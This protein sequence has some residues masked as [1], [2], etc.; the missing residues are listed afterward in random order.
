MY[1]ESDMAKRIEMLKSI[2]KQAVCGLLALFFFGMIQVSSASDDSSKAGY[3]KTAMD[4]VKSSRLFQ[5]MKKMTD[6]AG[7]VSDCLERNKDKINEKISDVN[8]KV[9][10][11]NECLTSVDNQTQQ[12]CMELAKNTY[13][14]RQLKKKAAE[15]EEAAKWS[16]EQ[17]V[18]GEIRVCTKGVRKPVGVVLQVTTSK[19]KLEIIQ[20]GGNSFSYFSVGQQVWFGRDQVGC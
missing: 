4:A 6:C 2:L 12:K 11:T 1:R 14:K 13:E 10:L 7:N 17:V 5:K 9:V 8:E 18:G 3:S 20:A 15:M 16:H 19:I